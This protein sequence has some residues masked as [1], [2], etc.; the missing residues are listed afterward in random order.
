LV[1]PITH[2]GLLVVTAK[3]RIFTYVIPSYLLAGVPNW[4]LSYLRFFPLHRLRVSRDGGENA[5]RGS[6]T[7][8]NW[9][10]LLAA[11]YIE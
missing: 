4:V 10:L 11:P 2:V 1:K 9:L 5:F 7:V 8:W 3:Q 6:R